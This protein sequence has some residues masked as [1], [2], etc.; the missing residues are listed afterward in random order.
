VATFVVAF[1]LMW[2]IKLL[3]YPWKLR[4]EKDIEEGGL[5]LLE[6]GS[7]AYPMQ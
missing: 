7:L 2:V 6:H 3:P 5:D 4:V 1:V